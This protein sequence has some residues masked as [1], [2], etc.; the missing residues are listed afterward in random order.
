MG[1]VIQM[2]TA[3]LGDESFEWMVGSTIRDIV[4][5]EPHTWRIVLSNGGVC[6]L[7]GGTWRLSSTTGIISCSD[8]HLHQ[9]GLPKRV[10]AAREA[11]AAV[12]N[13]PVVS[14][15]VSEFAPDLVLRFDGPI[16]LELLALSRGYECWQVTHPSGRSLVVSGR[17]MPRSGR[18]DKSARQAVA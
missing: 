7:D 5:K 1:K 13:S 14:A 9:F 17:V 3:D 6:S 2:E 11:R 8:D 4:F 18:S 10:D 12:G 16:T 15:A